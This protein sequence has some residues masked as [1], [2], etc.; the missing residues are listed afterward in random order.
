MKTVVSTYYL[1]KID[2]L[3]F[4]FANARAQSFP[5]RFQKKVFNSAYQ[6]F[7]NI[8]LYLYLKLNKATLDK[9]NFKFNHIYSKDLKKFSCKLYH[10]IIQIL[11]ENNIIKVNNHY[12]HGEPTISFSKSYLIHKDIFYS[13]D[14]SKR[15]LKY[16]LKEIEIPE[17]IVKILNVKSI[18]NEDDSID[19]QKKLNRFNRGNQPKNE[20]SKIRYYYNQL[21]YD[22]NK[23]NEYCDKDDFLYNY[24]KR[25]LLRLNQQ[26]KFI[27]GRFYHPFHEFSKNFRETVLTFE[28]EKI[29]EIFDISASDMH[30]L[31]KYLEQND[32]IPLKELIEF[33]NDVKNDFRKKF[34][35]RKDGKCTSQVKKAFKVY[36]NL[37][38]DRYDNFRYN[39]IASKIDEYFKENYPH[40]REYIKETDDIWQISMNEEFKIMSDKM[41]SELEKHGIKSLTCHDAIYVKESVQVPNIKKMFYQNLDLISDRTSKMLEL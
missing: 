4:D 34:G 33:Q 1:N 22:E 35:V 10:K 32:D 37:K 18:N 2:S 40:I 27:K 36:L 13:I 11:S 29:K 39:S 26:P 30:M 16:Q 21:Q 31:A 20:V 3:A 41:V 23:L 15:K 12:F 8:S 19:T 28:G 14:E 17:K 25:R 6:V 38:K 9:T 5:K 7:Q 24:N